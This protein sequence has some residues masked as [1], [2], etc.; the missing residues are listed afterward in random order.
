MIIL[1]L[2]SLCVAVLALAL[3][4]Y[5]VYA[6]ALGHLRPVRWL[7]HLGRSVRQAAPWAHTP[8]RLVRLDDAVPQRG[9]QSV[10]LSPEAK[11]R[12]AS[13]PD[14]EETFTGYWREP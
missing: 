6:R 3:S 1:P 13:L 2:I 12:V 14:V 9:S 5:L 4:I 10:P 7:L 8:T 11:A